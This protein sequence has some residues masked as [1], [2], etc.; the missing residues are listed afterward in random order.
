MVSFATKMPK[1]NDM[2]PKRNSFSRLIKTGKPKKCF[3]WFQSLW[4]WLLVS[5]CIRPMV[6]SAQ[7]WQS[8][9]TCELKTTAFLFCENRGNPKNVST[10]FKVCEYDYSFLYASDPWLVRH[11]NGK[12]QWHVNWKQ[13]LF[14][15]E[16][17]GETQKMFQM[18]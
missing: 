18:V 2:S 16:K 5:I 14:S 17:T 6:S 11:K 9:M 3:N 4:I 15:F 13:Q 12:V 7:K 10:G 8:S 1:F